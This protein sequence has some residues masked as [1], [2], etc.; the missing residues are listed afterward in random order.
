[1]EAP[2][3]KEYLGEPGFKEDRA[4]AL[5]K[6]GLAL[7]LAWTSLGGDVLTIECLL[8]P[9]GS[10]LRLTGKLGEVMSESANIAY[11]RVRS[12][13]C[14]S[15]CDDELLSKTGSTS[16]SPQGDPQGRPPRPGSPWPAPCS[17]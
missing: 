15:G 4:H 6:P 14:G 16:M 12:T 3:L 13:V 2:D 8:V 5:D 7:G 11:S 17:L 10:G 9:G 1:V